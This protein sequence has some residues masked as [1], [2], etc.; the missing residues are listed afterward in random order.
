MKT[1][2][3]GKRLYWVPFVV[4]MA[5]IAPSCTA[6]MCPVSEHSSKDEASEMESD[7]PGDCVEDEIE[8]SLEEQA[9][10]DGNAG[11]NSGGCVKTK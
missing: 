2:R 7:A 11:C 1:F 10:F 9:F 8:L 4:A 3:W 6:E 5:M